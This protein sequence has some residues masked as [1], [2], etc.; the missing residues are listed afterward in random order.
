MSPN[1]EEW[2]DNVSACSIDPQF[3][4]ARRTSSCN[5]TICRTVSFREGSFCDPVEIVMC[6]LKEQKT[7]MKFCFFLGK[8]QTESL[9]M[10]QKAFKDKLWV[11]RECLNGFLAFST[12]SP[13]P[14]KIR[15]VRSNVK[16]MLNCFFDI[17]GIVHREFVPRG[18]TVNQEF[19]L[20]ILKRVR[21]RLRRTRPEL[22][23]SGEWLIHNNNAP[24]YTALRI[25]QFLTFQGMTLVPHPTYSPD[26][27]PPTFFLFP[28]MKSDLKGRR[29]DTL[30][31]VIAASTRALNSIQFEE[32][33]RCFEQSK[34]R[35]DK[36]ISSNGEYFEGDKCIFVIL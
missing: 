10:L 29:F 33:Q 6:D 1:A 35:L 15:Q 23:R 24:T 25:C 2:E 32:L 20:E 8:T 28:R 7:C 31:D 14:K 30:E 36:C 9:E 16:K 12:G 22:W 18:Q 26:L 3:S 13:R 11:V 5:N 21:E 19:Y 34:Q 27:A 17:Q 4:V